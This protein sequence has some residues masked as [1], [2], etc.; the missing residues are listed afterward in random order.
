MRVA[1]ILSSLVLSACATPEAQP[2]NHLTAS[3]D[4][5]IGQPVEVAVSRLG[6]PIASVPMGS[7]SVYGWGYNF[8]RS[9]FT[10]AAPGWVEAA[11]S[12]GGIFP[13]P[14]RTASD[15]CVIRMVVGSDGRIRTWDFQ[16]ADRGC[17]ANADRVLGRAVARVD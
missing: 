6:E 12:Q 17:R 14:R 2:S 1:I 4:A 7:D 16:D 13:A 9:E 8:T 11:D 5:M 3:L 15:N 10:N